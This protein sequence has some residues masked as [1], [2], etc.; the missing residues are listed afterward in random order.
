MGCVTLGNRSHLTL[1][2]LLAT[3]C[4]GDFCVPELHN[5]LQMLQA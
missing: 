1:C 2:T 4:T 3:Q 5:P